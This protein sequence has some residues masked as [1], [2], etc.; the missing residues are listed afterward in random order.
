M[1]LL[2]LP[3]VFDQLAKR[4][5]SFYPPILNVEHNEWLFRRATWSEIQVVNTKDQMEVWIPRRFL[6]EISS[7]EDPVVIVGLNKELEY[8]GGAVWPHQ[9]RLIEMPVAVNDV[10]RTGAAP[11]RPEPALVVGIKLESNPESRIGRLI[12][13]SLVVGVLSCFVVISLFRYQQLN[14]RFTFTARDQSFLELTAHDDYYS[15]VRKLG[16]PKESRW[17]PNTGEI[18]FQALDYPERSYVVILMGAEQREA[19]YVGTIDK[20]WRSVLHDVSL[21]RGGSTGPMLR[22]LKRF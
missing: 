16:P 14:P 5:F 19:R 18:Q 13:G 7:I 4:P 1:P 12:I 8:K 15:V 2:P 11:R 20:T 3:P 22:G 21:P 17:R 6:G 9:R 10:P